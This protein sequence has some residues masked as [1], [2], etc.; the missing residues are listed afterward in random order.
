MKKYIDE[1]PASQY[2][3]V[4]GTDSQTTSRATTFVTA[5]IIHRIGKGAKFFLAKQKRKPVFNLRHRIYTETQISLTA[6]ELLKQHGLT[7]V[8]SGTPIEIHL[9]VGNFGETKALVTELSGWVSA[10][11]YIVRIKPESYGASSVA[12]RYTK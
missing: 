4:I 6:V 8:M 2:K 5:L 1:D 7:D 9:D 3:M 10:V 12:D 11:G